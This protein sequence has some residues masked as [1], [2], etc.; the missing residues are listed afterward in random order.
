MLNQQQ[1]I[2]IESIDI[3]FPYKNKLK[4]NTHITEP[5]K[6]LSAKFIIIIILNMQITENKCLIEESLYPIALKVTCI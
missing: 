6:Y 4:V 3:L 5:F 1:N 2:P